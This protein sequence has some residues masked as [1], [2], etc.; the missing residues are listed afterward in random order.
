VGGLRELPGAAD[1]LAPQI[2]KIAVAN[3]TRAVHLVD[4]RVV[5]LRRSSGPGV[6]VSTSHH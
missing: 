3:L 2:G 6:R 1:D 5:L 4:V